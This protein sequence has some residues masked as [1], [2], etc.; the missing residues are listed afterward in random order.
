MSDEVGLV[1]VLP[2]GEDDAV[3]GLSTAA[4]ATRELVDGEVR[5]I[6]GEAYELALERLREHRDRLDAL[7]QALLDRETLDEDDAYEAA[8]FGH[9]LADEVAAEDEAARR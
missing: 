5:R 8:G 1:S 3:A 4:E 2:A 7:A 9:Q 6:V